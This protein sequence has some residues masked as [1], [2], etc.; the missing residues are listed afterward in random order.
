MSN[1]IY[2][3]QHIHSKSEVKFTSLLVALLQIDDSISSAVYGNFCTVR[4][5]YFCQMFNDSVLIGKPR[6]SAAPYRFIKLQF[7]G[8]QLQ[9]G[10]CAV[11]HFKI[12]DDRFQHSVVAHQTSCVVIAA[13]T[14][15]FSHCAVACQSFACKHFLH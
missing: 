5:G 12:R 14:E 2:T 6:I 7:N 8:H 13:L 15:K 10:K 3:K 1:S 9:L 11:F 4:S